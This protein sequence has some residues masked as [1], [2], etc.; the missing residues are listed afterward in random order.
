[1]TNKEEPTAEELQSMQR[2]AYYGIIDDWL[3]ELLKE[4]ENTDDEKEKNMRGQ[5]LPG[6]LQSKQ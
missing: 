3:E 2:W 1:M 5:R 6:T 4:T